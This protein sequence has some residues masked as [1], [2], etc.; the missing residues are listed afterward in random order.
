M[1][2][3][4][5]WWVVPSPGRTLTKRVAK[6][7]PLND[8]MRAALQSYENGGRFFGRWKDANSFK[9][10]WLERS[11]GLVEAEAGLHRD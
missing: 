3:G 11:N 2:Q 4:D 7:I 1:Q 6:A 9:H 8:L 10:R 5:G